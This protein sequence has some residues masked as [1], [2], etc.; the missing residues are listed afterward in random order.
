M[1][2][3]VEAGRDARHNAFSGHLRALMAAC[4]AACAA[5]TATVAAVI[6]APATFTTIVAQ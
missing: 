1:Q 3:R 6:T 5:A 2:L 4:I